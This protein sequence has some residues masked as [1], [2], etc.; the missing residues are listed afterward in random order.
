MIVHVLNNVIYLQKTILNS[1]Q[2][3]YLKV[4]CTILK[5]LVYFYREILVSQDLKASLDPRESV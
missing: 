5:T 2:P 4:N 1:G 3:L